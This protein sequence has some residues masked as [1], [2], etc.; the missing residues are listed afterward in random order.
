MNEKEL[1]LPD[2]VMNDLRKIIF[3][4]LYRNPP[5]NQGVIATEIIDK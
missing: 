1:M 4:T 5:Y 2:A 3:D